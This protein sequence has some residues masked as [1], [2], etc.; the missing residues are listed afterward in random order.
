MQNSTNKSQILESIPSGP[1][2]LWY[3]KTLAERFYIDM[4]HQL[5]ETIIEV[6]HN[7]GTYPLVE[8][9]CSL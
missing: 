7:Y 6:S 8:R 9:A 3:N 4:A 2:S 1:G 5:N